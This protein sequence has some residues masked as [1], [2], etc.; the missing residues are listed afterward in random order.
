MQIYIMRHGEAL[1]F[2]ASDE[3]RPLND[4]GEQQ[5]V[6]MAR[7]LSQQLPDGNLDLVLVSPYLRAQQTWAACQTVMPTAKKVLTDEGITPY[8]DSE[9]VASYLRALI[10]VEKPSS[11]LLVSHLPLVGYLTAEFDADNQ[12]PMF[13]TSSV[14]CIEFDPISEKSEVLWL[15]SPAQLMGYA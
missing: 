13:P 10:A 11:V 8:G 2:A 1:T 4:R 9:H 12:A 3:E 5:S 15:K 7:W 6:E 14:S